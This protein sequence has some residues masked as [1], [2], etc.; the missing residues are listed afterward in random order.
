VIDARRSSRL[1]GASDRGSATIELAV[2][3]PGLLLLFGLILLGG[4]AALAGGSVEQV[5]AEAA[6][7]ASLGRDPATARQRARNAADRTLAE[8][9]LQCESL[10]ITVDASGFQIPLGQPAAVTVRVGCLLRLTDLPLP[11][12]TARAV[13]AEA[14]SPLDPY[15]SRTG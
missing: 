14:V 8:Q 3:G 7:E 6:R 5:A 15:R 12:L 9:H 11:G 4:R 2:L 1:A 13:S 10:T